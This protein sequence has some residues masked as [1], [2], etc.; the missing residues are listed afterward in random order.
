MREIINEKARNFKKQ[1]ESAQQPGFIELV[2][3]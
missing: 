2:S 3:A 1:K